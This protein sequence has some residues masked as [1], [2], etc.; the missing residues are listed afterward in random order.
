MHKNEMFDCV[1][2]IGPTDT[3]KMHHVKNNNNNHHGS[4]VGMMQKAQLLREYFRN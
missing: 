1:V 4:I 3:M 2:L